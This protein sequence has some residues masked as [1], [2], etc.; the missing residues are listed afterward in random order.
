MNN[1][2]KSEL[3]LPPLWKKKSEQKQIYEKQKSFVLVILIVG[4]C[5]AA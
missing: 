2:Q 4:Y 1:K 3:H 5:L